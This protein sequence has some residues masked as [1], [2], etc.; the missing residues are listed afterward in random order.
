[1]TLADALKVLLS[2]VV[3]F[4][5]RVQGAHWNVTGPDF[6]Q[7]HKLFEQIYDDVDASI[8][9]IAENIRKIG[10]YTPFRLIEFARLRTLEDA[11][12]GVTPDALTDDL[13]TANQAVLRTL[14][15]TFA[16][17][18]AENQ[19]GILNFLADRIDQHQKWSWFLRASLGQK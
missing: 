5:H 18:S 6:S 8:D 4:T 3:T 1:M 13:Y 14:N 16:V 9:P 19:Q 15:A 7:Y 12:P 17:A 11:D 10:E 2:D